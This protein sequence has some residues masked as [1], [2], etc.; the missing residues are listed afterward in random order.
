MNMVGWLAGGATARLVIGYLAEHIG[1]GPAIA[2]AAA[3]YL[4][5]GALLLVAGLVF[6]PRDVRRL[7]S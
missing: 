6:I 3:V 1:L 7:R 4:V 2:S 5:A